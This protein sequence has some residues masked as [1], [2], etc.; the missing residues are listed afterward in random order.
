VGNGE[1]GVLLAAG[2]LSRLLDPVLRDGAAGHV[3]QVYWNGRR[4]YHSGDTDAPAP[5]WW[6]SEGS[7]ALPIGASSWKVLHR[8]SGEQVAA[9]LTPLPH[10]LLAGG[11]LFSVLL[12]AL[13]HQVRLNQRTIRFLGASNRA[14]D[15]RVRE[16]AEKDAAL[17]EL[18]QELEMRV[19]RRTS[20][21]ADA[22]EELEAF[23]YSVS[24][25]LRS[26]I[27]AIL[28]F[29]ALLEED[30]G[31]RLDDAGREMLSR[32]SA[33]AESALELL[34]GLLQL[35]RA[36]RAHLEP[37]EIDMA[38]LARAVFAEVV[39]ADGAEDAEL[40]V[41]WLP[42][43]FADRALL[44]NVLSNLFGNALKYSRGRD[45]QRVA[46][47]GSEGADECVYA[48]SDNGVGFDMRFS[49]KLFGVFERLHTDEEFQG[50]GVGLAMVARIVRRHG[51]RVWAEGR[52]DH[53]ATFWFS[54]PK[55]GGSRP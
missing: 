11:V 42:T 13:V 52:V 48:V 4:V 53:G 7:V 17:R 49:S 46:L 8:P 26:P 18:N 20:E 5:A 31:V 55:P 2:S 12:A 10:A 25:D 23:N 24:H 34:E 33:S 39:A 22:V 32:V 36:T 15:V 1:R 29:A 40:S 16:A 50:S 30:Y 45:K 43:A 19:E 28:N 21:L 14:L 37:V 51:G 44:T 9:M 35:S 54:L 3:V 27:G 38:A 41:G 6:R 47:T